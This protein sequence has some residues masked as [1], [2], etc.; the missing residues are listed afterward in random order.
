MMAALLTLLWRDV[1]GV[2]ELAR[3]KARDGFLWC[4]PT[5]VSQQAVSHRF[6]TFLNQLFE[7]VC[8]Y[9][10]PSSRAAWHSRNK[11]PLPESTQFT[12]LKFQKIWRIDGSTEE[13]AI[14]SFGI[15]GDVGQR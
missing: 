11:C 6:L 14:V 1:A 5:K 12:L 10:L 3:M 4:N 2:R 15:V 7:K 13:L 8:K 9:L